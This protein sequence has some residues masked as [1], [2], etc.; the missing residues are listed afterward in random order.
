MALKTNRVEVLMHDKFVQAQSPP[1]GVVWKFGERVL[2]QMSFLLLDRSSKLRD[3]SPIALWG[4]VYGVRREVNTVGVLRRENC[5]SFPIC[6]AD[7]REEFFRQTF[8][9]VAVFTCESLENGVL[10]WISSPPFDRAGLKFRSVDK[11]ESC[12]GCLSNGR[13]ASLSIVG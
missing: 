4:I 10:A 11:T 12:G 3:P 5:R 8:R 1:A 2:A 9:P 6:G 13:L 7:F